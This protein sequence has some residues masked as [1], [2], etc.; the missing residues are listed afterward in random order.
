MLALTSL[1]SSAKETNI[2]NNLT[3][4]KLASMQTFL[5]IKDGVWS[6][7]EIKRK[8]NDKEEITNQLRLQMN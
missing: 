7:P 1:K 3:V 6:F 8:E 4:N 2:V 5:T